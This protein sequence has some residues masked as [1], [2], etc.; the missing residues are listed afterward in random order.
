M[1][2]IT[3]IDSPMGSGKTTWAIE[4]LL[5]SDPEE[6]LVY[7]TPFLSE[8][9]RIITA[10]KDSRRFQTPINKG[11]GK[12]MAI[13][14]LLQNERD[15]AATHELFKHLDSDSH[16]YI[17]QNNYTL[18]LDEV[19]DVISPY[20]IRSGDMKILTENNMISIDEDGFLLWTSDGLGDESAYEEIKNLIKN[21]CL[22]CVNDKI[23]LWRYPP[24]IFKMFSKVYIL[25]YLFD[26]SI[27]CSYFKFNNIEYAKKSI[28]KDDSDEYIL[29]EYKPFNASIYADLINIYEGSLNRNIDQKPKNLS[30]SWYINPNSEDDIRQLKN[31]IYN[32]FKNIVKAKSDTMMWTCFKQDIEKLKGKGYTKSHVSCNC[33]ST[34]SY[35]DRENLAYM[36]N[37]YLNPGIPAYF[38]KKN[39]KIDEDM[40]AL[41][42]MIQWIWRS[43]I[44]NGQPINIYIPSIR[45]RK[46][47]KR[48]LR[49]DTIKNFE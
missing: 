48:W 14:G 4:N 26:A 29:T 7:I 43:R 30:K 23:L 36:V 32:Y 49:G 35:A 18:I 44:R 13:N 47:L 1:C 22:V 10:T 17:Q 46:L 37:R 45:M 25:T 2:K 3:V 38:K 24:E 28:Q 9:D 15:I 33:R 6:S 19:L 34:N 41:S 40:Y 42:E 31:N 8:I 11:D 12:L 27:M 5:K 21:K 39:I 20:N 16:K